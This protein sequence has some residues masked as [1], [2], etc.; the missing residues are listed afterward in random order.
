MSLPDRI[1]EKILKL[2]S[3]DIHAQKIFGVEI[4]LRVGKW[5]EI[6]LD[7]VPEIKN[8][9]IETLTESITEKYELRLKE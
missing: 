3:I 8:E 2:F 9:D 5:P 4:K 1:S 6:K 7:Y